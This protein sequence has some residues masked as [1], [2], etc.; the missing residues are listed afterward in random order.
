MMQTG[1]WKLA[2]RAAVT[3]LNAST[4]AGL[5]GML[6]SYSLNKKFKGKLDVGVLTSSI[7]GG[8]VSITAICA[9]CNPWEALLIGFTGGIVTTLGKS[10]G[11]LYSK[12]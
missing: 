3:T 5:W 12:F 2:T 6:Y 10:L 7:L 4:G 8:L 11:L 1:K 9:I